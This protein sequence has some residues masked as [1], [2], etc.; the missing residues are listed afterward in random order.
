V[1][2]TDLGGQDER[3]GA[4]GRRRQ[5]N[6]SAPIIDI[7]LGGLSVRSVISYLARRTGLTAAVA[8]LLV[9]GLLVGAPMAHASP[10]QASTQSSK[11]G[12]LLP[13]GPSDAITWII[14]YPSQ[15]NSN[16]AFPYT[17]STHY[18]APSCS[19]PNNPNY[20]VFAWGYTVSG[21]ATGQAEWDS[22]F[23]GPGWTC[24]AQAWVPDS[25]STDPNAQY[26][27]FD[28]NNYLANDAFIN[29]GAITNNW[30]RLFNNTWFPISDHMRVTLSDHNPKG[31]GGWYIAAYALQ[32]LCF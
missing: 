7:E 25:H 4:G 19:D 3:H 1:V 12:R 29:Q 17:A 15:T 22:P 27:I 14:C 20:G 32:F 26:Y 23:V 11:S 28:G 18:P 16:S 21:S 6:S 24:A 2:G 10:L 9:S 13:R 31:Q 8:M 30:S 5:K